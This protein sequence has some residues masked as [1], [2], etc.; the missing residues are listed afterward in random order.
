WS[1]WSG[2]RFR[3]W[4]IRQSKTEF[5]SGAPIHYLPGHSSRPQLPTLSVSSKK[6]SR[7]T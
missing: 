3:W 1:R 7:R 6:P 4:K 5:S 2:D